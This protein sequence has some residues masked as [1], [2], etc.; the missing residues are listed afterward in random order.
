MTTL[1]RSD[2]SALASVETAWVLDPHTHPRLE[3]LDQCRGHGAP[4]A[5]MVAGPVEWNTEP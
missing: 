4:V 1:V 2:S 3:L 5:P